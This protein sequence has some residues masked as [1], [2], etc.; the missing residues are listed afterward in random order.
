MHA[1]QALD[2]VAAVL[3]VLSIMAFDNGFFGAVR[4]EIFSAARD[5]VRMFCILPGNRFTCPLV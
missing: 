3:L 1:V 5:L 4:S 2:Q